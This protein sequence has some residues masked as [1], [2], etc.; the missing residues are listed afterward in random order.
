M[1]VQNSFL[2]ALQP[3][4]NLSHNG[5]ALGERSVVSTRP[6]L[7]V[8]IYYRHV[9]YDTDFTFDVAAIIESTTLQTNAFARGKFNLDFYFVPYRQIFKDSDRIILGRGKSEVRNKLPN[10]EFEAQ[11][12]QNQIP[13]YSLG[14]TFEVIFRDWLIGRSLPNSHVITGDYVF[15]DVFNRPCFDDVIRLLDNLGYINLLPIFKVLFYSIY[16]D[17]SGIESDVDV[18]EILDRTNNTIDVESILVNQYGYSYD[19]VSTLDTNLSYS[20]LVRLLSGYFTLPSVLSGTSFDISDFIPKQ[21]NI[22]NI[23]AYQKIWSDIYRNQIYDT[24]DYTNAFSLDWC[25]G[26]NN[27][28]NDLSSE[29]FVK[30]YLV[31]RFRQWKKDLY[32]GTYPSAQ[33]GDVAMT[34]INIPAGSM[35][36][37]NGDERYMATSMPSDT[38]TNKNITAAHA[39]Q[40]P[41]GSSVG[42]MSSQGISA[43]DIRYT[44]AMQRYKERLLRTGDKL[45]SVLEGRFGVRSHYI[46]DDYVDFLGSFEGTFNVNRVA[47]TTNEGDTTIGEL[48]AFGTSGISGQPIK[49]HFNDV[50]VVMAILTFVP[51]TEYNSMMIDVFNTKSEQMDFFQPDFDNLGLSPV[52]GFEL[53]SR[54]GN[55]VLGYTAR[56]HEYKSSVDKVHGEFHGSYRPIIGAGSFPSIGF[57]K[58]PA[59][60]GAFSDYVTPRDVYYMHSNNWL[61]RYYINPECM[62]SIFQVAVGERQDTDCF[63][64][65]FNFVVNSSQPMSVTGLPSL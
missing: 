28:I 58:N 1:S 6:G 14:N 60:Y 36:F 3:N 29:D 64:C 59:V 63:K 2:S 42:M 49:R 37:T 7:C 33:F 48:G 44:M 43:V 11:S 41:A 50:G 13:T 24:A 26:F 21:V 46:E 5:F 56:Y 9:S 23:C 25:D 57:D 8:P 53:D 45:R 20:F 65:D 30:I 61:S 32:T 15:R 22:L 27:I 16:D 34:G 47:G 35:F 17:L 19:Y 51:E 39:A 38:P 12:F 55:S 62:N 31:P 52:F 4:P 40:L 10:T 18:D 54:L